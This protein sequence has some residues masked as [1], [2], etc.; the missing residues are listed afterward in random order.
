MGQLLSYCLTG[1][2]D[3]RTPPTGQTLG[4]L[5]AACAPATPLVRPLFIDPT[6][7]KLVAVKVEQIPAEGVAVAVDRI[8]PHHAMMGRWA[9]FAEIAQQ[10]A[11]A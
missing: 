3:L 5:V 10:R 9:T 7:V 2:E 4:R 8:E 11:I 1:D 6:A